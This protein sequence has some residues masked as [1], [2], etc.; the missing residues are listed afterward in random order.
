MT[1][2]VAVADG[3]VDEDSAASSVLMAPEES[4]LR[5][6]V[7]GVWGVELEEAR[8]CGDVMEARSL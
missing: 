3:S 4:I 8:W 2:G 7:R 1:V 6:L 5:L